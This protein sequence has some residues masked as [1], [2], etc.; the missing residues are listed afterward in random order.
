[1]SGSAPGAERLGFLDVARGCAALIV[2]LVHG[3]NASAPGYPQWAHAAFTVGFAG[4]VLLMMVSGFVLPFSLERGGPNAS[5]WLR[6]FFRLYPAYWLSMALGFGLTLLGGVYVGA[7][8]AL[9]TGDWALNATMLQG[10][11]GRPHVW[12][13]YW[14]LRMEL[15]VYAVFAVL[16]LLRLLHR[17]AL[18]AAVAIPAYVAFGVAKPLATGTTFA[19]GGS[20]FLAFAPLIGLLARDRVTGR[21]GGRPFAA[22]VAALVAGVGAIWAVNH[23]VA[24]ADMTADCLRDLAVTWGLAGGCLFAL[25]A[26]RRRTLPAP[27]QWLGRASF[28]VYLF[29]P[30]VLVLLAPQFWPAWRLIPAL[31]AGTS[32]V[33]YLTHPFVELPG[34]ALGRAIDRRWLAK[35]KPEPAYVS[36][37]A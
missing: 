33:S 36:R 27:L 6:R 12:G 37:A 15:T 3:L 21:L 1:M 29:H 11:F 9:S 26:T 4:V 24:P 28:S 35:R 30:F 2:L 14:T 17:P 10:F 32:A 20:S 7:V 13:V 25:A 31:I 22:I 23:A 5:F 16:Y 8:P 18:I 19:P 34:I